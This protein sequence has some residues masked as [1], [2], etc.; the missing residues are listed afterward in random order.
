MAVRGYGDLIGERR[1]GGED[2]SA[3]DNDSIRGVGD[4][5]Q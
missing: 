2:A 3:A 5:V 1:E 4:L